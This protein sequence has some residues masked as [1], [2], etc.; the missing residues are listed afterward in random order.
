M[1]FSEA[2]VAVGPTLSPR[3]LFKEWKKYVEEKGGDKRERR[4]R[5]SKLKASTCA[6]DDRFRPHDEQTV[7]HGKKCWEISR[8]RKIR[9]LH[10]KAVT[11]RITIHH[12]LPQ[13]G[14]VPPSLPTLRLWD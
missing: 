3:D 10:H 9:R 8:E 12:S 14:L 5:T 6:V 11:E 7:R 1:L 13:M 2:P 4:E